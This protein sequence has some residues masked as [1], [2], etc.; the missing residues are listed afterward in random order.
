MY[1]QRIGKLD[2]PSTWSQSFEDAMIA[3]SSA[4]GPFYLTSQPAD[5]VLYMTFGPN[6][7]IWMVPGTQRN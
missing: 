5:F 7:C 1:M 2:I 6:E 4:S 3:A